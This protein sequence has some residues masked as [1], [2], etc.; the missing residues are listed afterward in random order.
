MTTNLSFIQELGKSKSAT[1]GTSLVTLYVLPESNMSIVGEQLNSEL[2]TSQNIKDKNVR[3]GVR[4]ALKS[5]IQQVKSY[6]YTAHE[7]G[8]VLCAGE[9]DYCV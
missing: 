9:L 3:A 7:N 2:S 4:D 6:G 5:L 8:L 1:H